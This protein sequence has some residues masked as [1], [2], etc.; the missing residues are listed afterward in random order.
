[1]H[2]ILAL[3]ASHLNVITPS[4]SLEAKALAHKVDAVRLLNR[5]LSTPATTPADADARFA[6]VM[7]L[8]YQSS[9]ML[10]GLDD[11]MTMLRGCVL[12]GNLG[13]ESI[14]RTFFAHDYINTIKEE[15]DDAYQRSMI[16][17][18]DDAISSLAALQPLCRP[19]I[20]CLY[21]ALL[22]RLFQKAYVSQRDG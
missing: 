5:A 22:V 16:M 2:S 17:C 18:L 11:F 21:N 19:G 4:A 1:M 9:C 7:V 8:T 6:A 10:D 20:E 12:A 14:F 13:N 3:G 15:Q